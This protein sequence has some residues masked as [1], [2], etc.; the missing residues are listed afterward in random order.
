MEGNFEQLAHEIWPRMCSWILL[1]FY[2]KQIN[3]ENH[4]ICQDIMISY[5][6]SMLKNLVCFAEVVTY[7]TY[8]SKHLRWSFIEFRRSRLGF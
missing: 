6:E 8:K 5:M 3:S 7:A 2:K 1:K 4:E